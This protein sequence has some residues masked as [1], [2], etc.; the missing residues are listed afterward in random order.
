MKNILDFRQHNFE[1]SKHLNESESPYFG[2]DSGKYSKI[3]KSLYNE[4]VPNTGPS[5]YVMNLSTSHIYSKSC[6]NSK[7]HTA[8]SNIILEPNFLASL[9]D[10]LPV[11][12]DYLKYRSF[13]L[14]GFQIGRKLIKPANYHKI[15]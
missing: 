4:F 3:Y 7:Y 2:G 5:K 15:E 14:Y 1:K 6:Y 11:L 9:T 10:Y 12:I 13:E 8:L